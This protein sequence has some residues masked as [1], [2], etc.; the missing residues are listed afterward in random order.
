MA[1]MKNTPLDQSLNWDQRI[2]VTY[3]ISKTMF[4]KI[5]EHWLS[6]RTVSVVQPSL[7]S[8]WYI[9]GA[10]ECD[11]WVLRNSEGKHTL[12]FTGTVR[13]LA[14]GTPTMW[15]GEEEGQEYISTITM[16]P[17]IGDYEGEPTFYTEDIRLI[18]FQINH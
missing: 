10:R 16:G 11:G 12:T 6:E 13:E 3:T 7:D 1:A 9:Q 2:S 4:D 5:K 8:V 17:D 18:N 14:G 15:L